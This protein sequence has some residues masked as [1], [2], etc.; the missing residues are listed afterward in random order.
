MRK[1]GKSE[2]SVSPIVFGAFAIGG[3]LWGGNDERDSIDAIRASL[4]HGVNTMDTAAVYALGY[5][6][7]LVGKAIKDRP[8]DS[9]VIATKCGMRWNSDEGTDPWPQKDN[10]GRDVVIRKN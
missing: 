4:D 3:W 10:Q 5:S 7:E 6:E 1:L 2:V 8:R 9:V